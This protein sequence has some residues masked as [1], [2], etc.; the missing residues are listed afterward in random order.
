M[1][2]CNGEQGSQPRP[3]LDEVAQG[4]TVE[5]VDEG[6]TRLLQRA[7]QHTALL[8]RARGVGGIE[9]RHQGHV[10]LGMPHDLAEPDCLGGLCEPQAATSAADRRDVP[11][12]TELMSNLH[13]VVLGDTVAFGDLGNGREPVLLERKVHQQAQRVVGVDRQAQALLPY[14]AEENI[15]FRYC[16]IASAL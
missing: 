3:R 12:D 4:K 2:W 16:F 6:K 8:D 7:L 1:A 5:H 14:G 10:R 13:E 9:A 15:Y 11:G